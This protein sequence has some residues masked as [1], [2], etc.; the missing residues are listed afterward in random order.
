MLIEFFKYLI[1]FFFNF[2]YFPYLPTRDIID[3][4][5]FFVAI[6]NQ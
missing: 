6:R 4:F 5:F 2:F 3:W 1:D